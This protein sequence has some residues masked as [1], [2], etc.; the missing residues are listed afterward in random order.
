MA[1]GFCSQVMM[2]P[3]H[4]YMPLP[5]HQECTASNKYTGITCLTSAEHRHTYLQEG[6]M[7][8]LFR[9]SKQSVRIG[10]ALLVRQHPAATRGRWVSVK[11]QLHVQK[12]GCART[13]PR[14][15]PDT[16]TVD[17]WSESFDRVVQSWSTQ[18]CMRF[19]A[20]SAPPPNTISGFVST[21]SNCQQAAGLSQ[22][23]NTRGSS[24]RVSHLN[25]A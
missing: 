14:S 20:H 16:L 15:R 7:P 2:P 22:R 8:S 19:S 25:S 3:L 4:V 12:H 21:S 17:V 11:A 6:D 13:P 24:V 5:E 10:Y 18:A 9:H 23:D 1:F